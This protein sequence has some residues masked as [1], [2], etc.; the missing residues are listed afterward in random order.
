[1]FLDCIFKNGCQNCRLAFDLS[2]CLDSVVYMW[3]IYICSNNASI[4]AKTF[5]LKKH[6]RKSYFC[7]L[8][9]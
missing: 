9:E 4:M 1:M 5:K 8:P 6:A 7:R 3:C 2:S